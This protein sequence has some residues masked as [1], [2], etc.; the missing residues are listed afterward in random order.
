MINFIETQIEE[1]QDRELKV[2]CDNGSDCII[3]IDVK[4][5]GNIGKMHYVYDTDVNS[6]DSIV[7]DFDLLSHVATKFQPSFLAMI[8]DNDLQIELEEGSQNVGYYERLINIPS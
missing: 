1:L 4:K 6:E 3:A 5:K 8:Q 7:F 2:I